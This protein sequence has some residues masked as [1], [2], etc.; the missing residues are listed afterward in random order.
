MNEQQ[1]VETFHRVRD[2]IVVGPPPVLQVT[3]GATRRR[4]RTQ[5]V[6]AAAAVAVVSGVGIAV[7][8]WDGDGSRPEPAVRLVE[9]PAP[10]AWWGGGRLHVAHAVVE[11][12]EP[13]AIVPVGDGVVTWT[14]PAAGEDR[15]PL[16]H[17]T[18]DGNQSTIGEKA[19]GD[20][21]AADTTTGWVAWVDHSD[22]A[23]VLVVFD[24][25]AGEEVARRE[26]ADDGPRHEVLDEGP[27]PIAIED[28]A[29]FYADW[30]A[31]YRWDVAAGAE[32]MQVTDGD[33]YL[34]DRESGVDLIRSYDTERGYG[35]PVLRREGEAD[36]ELPDSAGLLSPD[37]RH[38]LGLTAIGP[39]ARLFDVADQG[40]RVPTG[41]TD[42]R[43]IA[44]VAFGRDGTLTFAFGTPWT[45]PAD[46][47]R[48]LAP[49]ADYNVAPFDLVSC[50]I[51]TATCETVVDGIESDNVVL[52]D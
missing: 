34:V 20:R 1:V 33:T 29:V 26:L 23:T 48:D 37:G 24:T 11:T 16:V 9:N 50:A 40:R 43:A 36:A 13:R 39:Y 51:A 3:A 27:Y 44:D 32:P 2:D 7:G 49:P 5:V 31:D 10:V 46:G 41:L 47:S 4:R 28:G 19:Y 14:E 15:G 6:A 22:D 25:A 35:P 52:P 42:D 21:L 17:V 30:D 8:L 45:P 18:D 12:P 38:V